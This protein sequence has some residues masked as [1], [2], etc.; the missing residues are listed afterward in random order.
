MSVC[1]SLLEQDHIHKDPY[2]LY[3]PSFFRQVKIVTFTSG[4]LSF[5]S[6]FK[7]LSPMV[8]KKRSLSFISTALFLS[9]L[10]TSFRPRVN[11]EGRA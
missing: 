9:G 3:M 7:S 10:I 5:V 2:F 4:I 8:K 11:P 1:I 6:L